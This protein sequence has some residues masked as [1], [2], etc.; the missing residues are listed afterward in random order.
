MRLEHENHHDGDR[1]VEP[2]GVRQLPFGSAS[3]TGSQREKERR[4]H[5]RQRDDGRDYMAGQNGKVQCAHWAVTAK[6]R[7][8]VQCVHKCS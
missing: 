8:A 7:V 1:N 5:H 2:N 3:R 6:N 4:E